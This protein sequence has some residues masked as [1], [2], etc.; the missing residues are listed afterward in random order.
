MFLKHGPLVWKR[1]L[2]QMSGNH[3]PTSTT[4]FTFGNCPMLWQLSLNTSA[5]F[6]CLNSPSQPFIPFLYYW[7][8]TYSQH[9]RHKFSLTIS[10]CG[11]EPWSRGD[12]RYEGRGF[13]SRCRILDGYCF[14]WICCKIVLMF[15]WKRTRWPIFFLKKQCQFGKYNCC[16][17]DSNLSPFDV[18]IKQPLC[19][20][21]RCTY[22]LVSSHHNSLWNGVQ[23]WNKLK[24]VHC[25]E[26]IR[27][28]C[29]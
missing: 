12:S 5:Y 29:D 26:W 27:L 14:I 1:L 3:C 17:L 25:L 24:N 20:Q 6:H 19:Q 15:V 7:L 21:C 10:V 28:S 4:L 9:Y 23:F 2:C 8:F 13:E 16:R 22:Y 18:G 11:R